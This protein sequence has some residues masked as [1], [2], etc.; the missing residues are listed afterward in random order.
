LVLSNAEA[1][2]K[3]KVALVLVLLLSLITLPLVTPAQTA[4]IH[5]L[6]IVYVTNVP[7]AK[8]RSFPVVQALVQGL[9]ESGYV[10]GQ[11]L[12]LD[13]RSAEGQVNRVPGL[14]AELLHQVDAFVAM[15]CEAPFHAARQ[16]TKTIPI[17]VA[18]CNDD[19]VRTGVVDG[20]ARPG[21]NITGLSKV[22]PELAAK[23]S[24]FSKRRFP[25]PPGWQS[26]GTPATLTSR[27]T[28][29]RSERRPPRWE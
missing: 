18:A 27:K 22:T 15:T 12:V 17:V 21:G 8:W 24:P 26:C 9:R 7:E 10:E 13:I 20:L 3:Y 14:V 2:M 25:R 5:R 23:D 28:G 6:G 11:N 29:K 16:A 4:I 19:L 1:A